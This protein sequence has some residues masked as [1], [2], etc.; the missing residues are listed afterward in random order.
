MD[1][2]VGEVAGEVLLVWSAVRYGLVFQAAEA[3]EMGEGGGEKV[4][5]LLDDVGIG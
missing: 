2:E 5:P 3:D 1:E 4:D